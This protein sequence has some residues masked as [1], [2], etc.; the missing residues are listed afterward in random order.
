M[1]AS[2]HEKIAAI[3]QYL[4]WESQQPGVHNDFTDELIVRFSD[5]VLTECDTAIGHGPGHQSISPCIRTGEHSEHISDMGH[6]WSDSD[7][8]KQ[9]Y[10]RRGVTYRLAFESY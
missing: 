4:E 9:T 3:R 1:T 6:D 8:G 5:E 2:K 10:V 7:I